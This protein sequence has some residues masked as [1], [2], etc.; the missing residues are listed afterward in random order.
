M[1]ELDVIIRPSEATLAEYALR[2][3]ECVGII[4]GGGRLPTLVIEALRS[5][6]TPFAVLA[7]KGH[8]PDDV[9]SYGAPYACV[10]LGE[11]G[12][13]I[14][15]LKSHSCKRIV[16]A[17]HIKRP[18]LSSLKLDI[19]TIS[20]LAKLGLSKLGGG[21]DSI[22]RS[23]IQM[24]EREGFEIV[25]PHV[26]TPG[27]LASEGLIGGTPLSDDDYRDIDTGTRVLRALGFED[28]GQSVVVEN[29][30]VLG[31]EAAEGTDALI[32]RCAALKKEKGRSGIVVKFSKSGQDLRIDLPAIGERTVQH[33]ADA[34]LRGI[35]V[36]AGGSLVIDK[37]RVVALAER[38][39]VFV[40]GV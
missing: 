14:K 35:A 16:F 6:E 8:T 23:I 3:K 26:V 32:T 30:Y 25:S 1:S 4:A 31:I 18:S 19:T 5:S 37:E 12:K 20:M 22:M 15:F 34:G 39:G 13:A 38:L 21:D 24:F 17:G 29:G 28:I 36:Q 33:V 7:L 40:V 27:L 11:L 2:D 9:S 10:E